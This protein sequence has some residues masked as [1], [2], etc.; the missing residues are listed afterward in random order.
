VKRPRLKPGLSGQVPAKPAALP[1][2]LRLRGPCLSVSHLLGR[3]KRRA[4][5]RF[6]GARVPPVNPSAAPLP[7]AASPD[8]GSR[9]PL[10]LPVWRQIPER[11]LPGTQHA[12]GSMPYAMMTPHSREHLLAAAH[13]AR[14][15]DLA[16]NCCRPAEACRCLAICHS[17]D[18]NQNNQSKNGERVR[19]LPL[20][21][22]RNAAYEACT[23]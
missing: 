20:A 19:H 6:A 10:I 2:P 5:A 3:R 15:R 17:M 21:M 1:P 7:A 11:T 16:M 12:M 13:A 14:C 9:K 22:G 18:N 23:L 8:D 4:P